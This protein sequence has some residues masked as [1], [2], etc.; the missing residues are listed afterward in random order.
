MNWF[1]AIELLNIIQHIILY[2][3][4]LEMIVD[5]R[6]YEERRGRVLAFAL[7]YFRA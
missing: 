6:I 7:L 1:S 3:Y 5:K 4:T 2:I